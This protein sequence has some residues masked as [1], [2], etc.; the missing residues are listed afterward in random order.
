MALQSALLGLSRETLEHTL[1][2]IGGFEKPAVRAIAEELKLPV[3]NKPD[4]Q[5]IC[6][7]PG[8]DYKQFIDA[9]L[10]EQGEQLPDTSGD[11]VTT[12]GEGISISYKV[13]R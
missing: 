10:H 9:Y 13:K 3:F 2:P 7:V 4:S 11:L 1:L 6:F 8:G 12:S 5:E